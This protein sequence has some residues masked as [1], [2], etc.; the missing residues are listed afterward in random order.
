M[1]YALPDPPGS[2]GFICFDS[3]V[4][5]VGHVW[6]RTAH[7]GTP[8]ATSVLRPKSF[9]CSVATALSSLGRPSNLFL[10]QGGRL[11]VAMHFRERVELILRGGHNL[12]KFNNNYRADVRN[13][14]PIRP[15]HHETEC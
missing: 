6:R 11:R 9:L 13:W 3:W 4:D 12:L 7:P 10:R 8:V 15:P 2:T 5:C 1:P 14:G